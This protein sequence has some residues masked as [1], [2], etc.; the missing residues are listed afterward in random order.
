MKAKLLV[1]LAED[2]QIPQ[3]GKEDVIALIE[4]WVV[5]FLAKS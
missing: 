3:D 2:T 4:S 5:K 1:F